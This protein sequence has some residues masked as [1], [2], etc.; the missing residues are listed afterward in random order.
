[1][2]L[3]SFRFYFQFS[4]PNLDQ[5]SKNTQINSHTTDNKRDNLMKTVKPDFAAKQQTVEMQ[6]I[7]DSS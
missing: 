1:M 6:T 3:Q 5:I 2:S 7:V 4:L